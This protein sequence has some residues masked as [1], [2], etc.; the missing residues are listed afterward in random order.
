MCT[1][2]TVLVGIAGVNGV[3]CVYVVLVGAPLLL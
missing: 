2:A 3:V 1:T